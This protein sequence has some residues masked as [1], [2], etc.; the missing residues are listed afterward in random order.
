MQLVGHVIK[1]GIRLGSVRPKRLLSPAAQQ[2]KVLLRLLA[3][4]A[5]TSFGRYYG[6]ASLLWRRDP[7]SAFQ[8]YVP[9]HDYDKIYQEWWHRSRQDEPD[10]CWPGIVPWYAMSSGTST[11]ASKYI[12]VTRDLI[13]SMSRLSRQAFF[14]MAHFR[15]PAHVFA[16]QMLMVGST[17]TLQ[18]E[19]QHWVGDLSGIIALNRPFWLKKYY[20]PERD[21]TDL[22]EWGERIER[23]AERAHRWDIG[24]IVGNV[25]WV[26]MIL[27]RIIARYDLQHIHE[28]W[29]NFSLYMHSGIFFEPYQAT[30]ERLLGRPVQYVDCYL[31]S[32]GFIGY[33]RSPLSRLHRLATNAGIFYEFV[34]FDD[35]HFDDD[36]NLRPDARALWLPEVEAGRPYALLL[37]TEA[38]CWRYLLGDTI[39]FADTQRLLFRITGRTKHFLSVTGEHV[40]VDNLNAAVRAAEQQLRLGVKEFAVAAEPCGSHWAHHWYISAERPHAHDPERCAQVL[41]NYLQSIND[42]YRTERQY[43]LQQVRVTL[44]PHQ[45]FYRWLEQHGKMNGQAKIPRVLKGKAQSSWEAY[46]RRHTA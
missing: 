39:E 36:G 25:A 26:Q 45:V 42:D 18:R 33:Q 14:D 38:G 21:I 11:A 20:R 29:P 43:A 9:I 19:G 3:S 41:D 28:L 27:E 10:V 23:I 30:F 24:F 6:F 16:C 4:A 44:L 7:I 2:R 13:R 34:P 12:P 46:L 37:S 17:T 22:P 1:T 5:H 8:R 40:S 31:A 32:E 35:E 15:L